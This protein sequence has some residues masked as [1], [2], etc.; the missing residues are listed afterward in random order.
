MNDCTG[1]SVA[2]NFNYSV[3]EASGHGNIHFLDKYCRNNLGC[4]EP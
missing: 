4:L 3:I 2:Q 1:I